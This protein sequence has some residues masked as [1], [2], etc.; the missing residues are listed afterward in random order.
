MEIV[1]FRCRPI[2]TLNR[3][4]K[5]LLLL[6]IKTLSHTHP[7]RSTNTKLTELQYSELCS[8][9]T[10]LLSNT[11]AYEKREENRIVLKVE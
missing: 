5:C 9:S 8:Y 7:I 1:G 10:L 3:R 6:V 2:G 4:D 11:E